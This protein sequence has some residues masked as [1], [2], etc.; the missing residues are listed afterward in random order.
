[1]AQ[2]EAPVR[3][4]VRNSPVPDSAYAINRQLLRFVPRL[5]RGWGRSTSLGFGHVGAQ[6]L[7]KVKASTTTLRLCGSVTE[8][9]V[10]AE[11]RLNE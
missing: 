1:M 10:L 8:R 5:E 6:L 7:D 9:T 3:A 4:M 11:F 2:M